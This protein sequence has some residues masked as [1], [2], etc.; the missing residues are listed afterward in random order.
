MGSWCANVVLKANMM[1]IFILH[2]VS[3]YGMRVEEPAE[4][5]GWHSGTDVLDK[6]EGARIG[7]EGYSAG[8]IGR[9]V[10]STLQSAG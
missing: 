3:Q 1:K 5:K 6:V 2:M 4:A 9:G 10:G 8:I 7:F